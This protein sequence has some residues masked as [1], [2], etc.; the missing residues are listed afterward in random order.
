MNNFVFVE[1]I[2]Q[3]SMQC[4]RIEFTTFQTTIIF[5]S[6][7]RKQEEND[8]KNFCLKRLSFYKN[9]ETHKL[10]LMIN[11]QNWFVYIFMIYWE[12]IWSCLKVG[13]RHWL[14]CHKRQIKNDCPLIFMRV[15]ESG[16]TQRT[17]TEKLDDFVKDN[18][19]YE[20]KTF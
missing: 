18:E 11:Y 8:K 9:G 19:K 17:L 4:L 20:R 16:I 10:C 14:F 5:K 7:N 13:D 3:Q 12:F 6:D 1:N 2:F 15:I